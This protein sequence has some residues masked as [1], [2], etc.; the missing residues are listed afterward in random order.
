MN[1][2][3]FA[4]CTLVVLGCTSSALA[5]ESLLQ[6]AWLSVGAKDSDVSAALGYRMKYIGFEVGFLNNSE[7]KEDVL[8]WNVPH[9]DYTDLGT[10]RTGSSFGIDLLGF[11]DINDRFALYAGPGVYAEGRQHVAQSNATGWYYEESDES[12]VI[13][14]GSAGIHAR[15]SDSVFAGVGYHT[16][17]GVNGKIGVRF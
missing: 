4:A 13:V 9:N 14:A 7:F 2:T 11:Y 17:R 16:I 5:Q 6:E 8:K 3:K 10:K 15:L 12:R 1:F